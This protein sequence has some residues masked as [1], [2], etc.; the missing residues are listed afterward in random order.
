MNPWWRRPTAVDGEGK[1]KKS[2]PR[3]RKESNDQSAD[4]P[5]SG[6]RDLLE[7][8]AVH[9]SG[10]TS[11]TPGPV[12]ERKRQTETK[13][14]SRPQLPSAQDLTGETQEPAQSAPSKDPET[15]STTV[16]RPA[17]S[18]GWSFRRPPET[19]ARLPRSTTEEKA[20]GRDRD[21]SESP[22]SSAG[23]R[24]RTSRSESPRSE[25]SRSRGAERSSD[26]RSARSS[27]DAEPSAKSENN[28]EEPAPA[29]RSDSS[30][31]ARV[32]R[33]RGGSDS[34][35]TRSRSERARPKR[36]RGSS[37]SRRRSESRDVVS[38][39]DVLTDHESLESDVLDDAID[40][41]RERPR[42]GTRGG[43]KRGTSSSSKED[44]SRDSS[45]KRKRQKKPKKSGSHGKGKAGIA[46]LCDASGL[47]GK[48][49]SLEKVRK[50]TAPKG[51]ILSARVYGGT[52]DDF[53]GRLDGVAFVLVDTSSMDAGAAHVR[54]VADAIELCYTKPGIDTFALVAGDDALAP[55]AVKL[56]ELDKRV[57]AVTPE[58]TGRSLAAACDDSAVLDARTT[59][60]SP[61]SK[62]SRRSKRRPSSDSQGRPRARSEAAAEEPEDVDEVSSPRDLEDAMTAVREAVDQ[63]AR[64]FGDR[65]FPST[66]RD[67]LHDRHD[68]DERDFG[69]STFEE[70]LREAEKNEALVMQR[71]PRSGKLTIYSLEE[72]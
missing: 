46:V 64:R 20:D 1:T 28:V 41:T 14:P 69:F 11:E 57:V 35:D 55:L 71:D 6:K 72:D 3:D 4:I 59:A 45:R 33:H 15:S 54:M 22:R 39:L 29:E 36:A 60:K 16:S 58:G 70:F 5:S 7:D 38:S 26:R 24:S 30:P 40:T 53:S 21:A 17:S 47:D 61:D 13:Q 49:V 9:A 50:A 68:I 62:R 66:L 63:L 52:L 19:G 18:L 8:A 32:S 56:R 31:R 48:P 37:E 43:T 25:S 2:K 12:D 27:T 23:A 65:I 34:R 10:R 42:R 44:T 67:T 51:A